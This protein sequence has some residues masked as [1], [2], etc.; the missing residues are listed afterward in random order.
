VFLLIEVRDVIVE[1]ESIRQFF[2]CSYCHAKK[3][4][5]VRLQFQRAAALCLSSSVWKKPIYFHIHCDL[6]A[7][8]KAKMC[9]FHDPPVLASVQST[10]F[11]FI[12]V[13][14]AAMRHRC[15]GLGK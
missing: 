14:G 10:S 7:T 2:Q 9:F 6:F 8:A 4:G 1:N 11:S 15:M 3:T 13:N 12:F 5:G